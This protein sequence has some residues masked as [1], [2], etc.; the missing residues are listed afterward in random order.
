MTYICKPKGQIIIQLKLLPIGN[1]LKVG[2]DSL[3]ILHSIK[4]LYLPSACTAGLPVLPLCLHLLN[5]R[6]VLQHY[7]A[8]IHRCVSGN[9]LTLKP[10]GIDPG[11]HTSM[12][13]MGMSEEHVINFTV[14]HR[15]LCI[16]IYVI[17]LLHTA[18]N[19]HL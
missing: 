9:D 11:Q 16:L 13:Y 1:P 14:A 19:Q 10:S 17:P 15:Q 18:V 12:V 4:S 8:Q 5:M 7:A 6:T 3:R 2:E